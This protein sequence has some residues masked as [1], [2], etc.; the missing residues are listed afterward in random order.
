MYFLPW[1][2]MHLVSMR[3]PGVSYGDYDFPVDTN[4]GIF[5]TAVGMLFDPQA[6]IELAPAILAYLA[7]TIVLKSLVIFGISSLLLGRDTRTGEIC[8]WENH[9]KL[10]STIA[11]RQ[12]GGPQ[13][14]QKYLP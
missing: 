8:G 2:S 12:V 7:A 9:H 1:R 13:V 10:F 6:A 11:H 5:F 3:I 4:P 14:L